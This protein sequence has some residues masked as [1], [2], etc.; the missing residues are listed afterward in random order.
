MK[1]IKTYQFSPNDLPKDRLIKALLICWLL[2]LLTALSCL[3]W[4]VELKYNL[5]TPV[6]AGYNPVS[7]DTYISLPGQLLS[8]TG[9]PLFIHFFNPLCP[10]SRF[11][12]SIF[13]KIVREYGSRMDFMVVV[14]STKSCTKEAITGQLGQGLTVSF[15]PH[16]ARLCGVYSTPQVALLDAEH[17]LYYRGNYNRSRY[18]RDEKTNYA[19]IAIKE[20][21]ASHQKLMM[22]ALALHAYGCQAPGCT[23]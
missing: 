10:C 16:I 17:K 13:R 2:L 19:E 21:F 15:N 14:M 23:K 12:K 4:F 20:L 7:I 18:C 9:R 8:K 6:P 22:D 11:N 5:P 3:F 1:K